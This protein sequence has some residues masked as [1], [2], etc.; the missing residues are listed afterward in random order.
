MPE[1]KPLYQSHVDA[2]WARQPTGC[3]PALP[4]W[5]PRRGT[6]A[7]IV[8]C[9]ALGILIGAGTVWGLL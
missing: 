7:T 2:F 4:W 3:G 9:L 5:R 8:S 6:V 1:P